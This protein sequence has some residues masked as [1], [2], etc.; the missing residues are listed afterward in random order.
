[1]SLHDDGEQRLRSLLP[2]SL[3]DEGEPVFAE[4][5]QAQAFAMTVSL[6]EAGLFSWSEWTETFSSHRAARESGDDD[7]GSF[8]YYH[9]W[10]SSL[11]SLVSQ[12]A[13][14]E[15]SGLV[16]LKERWEEAYRSTPHGVKVT[17]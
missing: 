13:G 6:F 12:R 11:E 9:D 17:L 4:P 14:I 16:N 7:P 2:Q 3:T 1:M 15:H 10:L 5:W 8:F